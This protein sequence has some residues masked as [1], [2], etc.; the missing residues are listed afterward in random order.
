MAVDEPS[1]Q[2]LPQP[3]QFVLVEVGERFARGF[4]VDVLN[5]HGVT[6][7][8]V[9]PRGKFTYASVATAPG[10]ATGPVTTTP[11]SARVDFPAT[12]SRVRIVEAGLAQPNVQRHSGRLGISLAARRIENRFVQG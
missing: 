2:H 6:I 11:V 4:E 1:V 9:S 5:H 7:R 3:P 8:R 12:A 10:V